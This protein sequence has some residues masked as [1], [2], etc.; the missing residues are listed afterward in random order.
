MT[1][2][3]PSAPSAPFTP[4]APSAPFARKPWSRFGATAVALAAC[5]ALS[6]APALAA[7]PPW[8]DAAFSYYAEA[9]PLNQVLAEFASS[10]SLS[11]D[12][13]PGFDA[14][15]SGRFA[16]RSPTEFI[17]RLA[18]VYGFNWFAHA[19][20]LFVSSNKD[21]QVRSIPT[22]VAGS[23]T[24]LRQVLTDLRILDARFGWGEL[25]DQ[26]VVVV[27]GP[28]AY[29]RLVESTVASLPK[30]P[31]GLQVAVFRLKHASVDDRSISYRDREI[32]TPGVATVLRNLVSNTSSGMA[33]RLGSA[34]GAA[35]ALSNF[36]ATAGSP[37]DAAK[38]AGAFGS[39]PRQDASAPGSAPMP[40]I[41]PSI[42]SDPRI[43]AIIV[44]DTPERI[45]IYQQLIAALDVPTPLIEIEAMIIDVN[46]SRLQELGISWNAVTRGGGAALGFG[47]IDQQVDKNTISAFLGSAGAGANPSTILSN[48]STYFISRL[49]LLEQQGDASIQARPSILTTENIGAVIDL[50][51]TFYIQTTSERT[52]L[53]TPVTAGTTL[54]VTPRLIDQGSDSAIRL[55]VDIE[56]GQIQ[57]GTGSS[58]LPT[59]RRG[60]VSTEASVRRDESLLIGGYN[61]VQTVKGKDKIPI[62]GDI[63]VLGALFSNASDQI[64]RRERLFLIRTKIVGNLPDA[65]RLGQG[66]QDLLALGVNANSSTAPAAS[67]PTALTF[68]IP[69]SSLTASAAPAPVALSEAPS[70]VPRPVPASTPPPTRAEQQPR[71]A[72]AAPLP[73]PAP[74]KLQWLPSASPTAAVET[75]KVSSSTQAGRD[76]ESRRILEKELERAELQLQRLLDRL[77]QGFDS[78][79]MTD[80]AA[81]TETRSAALRARADVEALRKE[82]S[83]LAPSLSR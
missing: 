51:E 63:P 66:P 6:S 29:V 33:A 15:V 64:Q 54:R 57:S 5:V 31:G 9:K 37:S 80:R 72:A 81:A 26:G 71:F 18:G 11:L 21:V 8:P 45:P 35:M 24:N 82:L 83:R 3:A 47:N 55:Y 41:R 42:Q 1:L 22:A 62:L 43:N 77:S 25:P 60:V 36:S 52:A 19:G 58:S 68:A 23:G 73:A 2:F 30:S 65:A 17:D 27:S 40:R 7:P 20:T 38:P 74:A 4:S 50:S 56:D 49:R 44:Q 32:T 59:V 69:S 14:P 76:R 46:T 70:A 16:M 39:N 12:V 13:T 10:F 34:A 61:S 75:A 53:V 79:Q 78:T 28:P 48:A 67:A